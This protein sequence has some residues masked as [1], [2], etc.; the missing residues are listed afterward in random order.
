MKQLGEEESVSLSQ[1]S[2]QK[3]D[4]CPTLCVFQ[5]FGRFITSSILS[6]FCCGEAISQNEASFVLLRIF[7]QLGCISRPFTIYGHAPLAMH[8]QLGDSFALT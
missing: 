1:G 5:D 7:H 6:D 3:D 2:C 4:I 8:Q